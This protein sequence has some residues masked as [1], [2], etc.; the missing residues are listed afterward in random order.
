MPLIVAPLIFVAFALSGERI[1]RTE[2]TNAMSRSQKRKRRQRQR[3]QLPRSTKPAPDRNAGAPASQ[4]A[5]RP[6]ATVPAPATAAEQLPARFITGSIL[7]HILVMTSTGA[8]GLMAIFVGDLANLLFLGQLQDTEI[9]AA[10]GYASTL[11]FFSVSIG[12]G[13][14]IGATSVVSPAIGAGQKSEARRLATSALLLTAI[15]CFAIALA[16]WPFL[17]PL[18]G[19]LGAQGRTLTLATEYLRVLY[20]T[21]PLMAVGMTCGGILRSA[22]DPRR[23]MYVTLSGAIINVILDPIFILALHYGLHGAAWASVIARAAMTAVG[24]WGVARVHGLLQWPDRSQLKPDIVRLLGVAIPAVATNLAT[25]A[26]NAFVTKALAGF[27]DA[28]IATWSVYGRVNPVAFGAVFALSSSIGPII[29]QN[30]GARNFARV[31]ETIIE[32]A[33]VT[34]AFTAV[35]WFTLALSPGWIAQ[36]F[37]LSG[38]SLPL[39]DLFCRW[40]PPFF[41][42]LGFLFVANAVFNVLRRPHYATLF[43]WGRATLGTVPFVMAGGH[44]AGA[45]GVFLGSLISGVIFGSGAL[46]FSLRLV[47]KL[48]AESHA[49]Q[50]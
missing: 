18:L 21:F 10:V 26:A 8:L 34:I 15:T 11:L 16:L 36:V 12:I 35:A 31:K 24:L 28:A 3:H 30:Y 29:G 47:D 45:S 41:A 14:S 49:D 38:D 46:W 1:A 50:K 6:A 37:G 7:R 33:R 22:G 5:Q 44:I 27:G 23:A 20:P 43:N 42:F 32:A 40:L 19:A 4:R 13:I 25:P 48:A 2:H 9:L 17:K 39:V